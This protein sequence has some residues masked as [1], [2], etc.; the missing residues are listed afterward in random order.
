MNGTAG[1]TWRTSVGLK[2]NLPGM[3]EGAGGGVPAA[4]VMGEVPTGEVTVSVKVN[5]AA[6]VTAVAWVSPLTKPARVAVKAGSAAPKA[7]VALLGVT[8]R[9]AGGVVI[10]AVADWPA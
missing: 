8:E 2:G 4:G 1:A 5:E 3:L 9:T 7:R 10:W 6:P